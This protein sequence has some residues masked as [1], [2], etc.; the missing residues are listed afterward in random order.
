MGSLPDDLPPGWKIVNLGDITDIKSGYGFP[1]EYQGRSYGDFP[2]AKVGDISK[3]V[4]SGGLD[5]DTA[6]HY[7][8]FDDLKKLKAHTIP[9]ESIVFAKIGEA[10]KLNRRAITKCEM[11]VD[12]NVMA[13][14]PTKA[15][16]NPY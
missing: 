8:D 16:T 11:I 7:L 6:D 2:F 1:K 12:N 15:F 13:L 14:I 9:R 10:I 5:I 3:A 4:S